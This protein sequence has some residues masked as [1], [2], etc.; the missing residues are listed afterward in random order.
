ME[1]IAR[2]DHRLVAYSRT[3]GEYLG[4]DCC[5]GTR[6]RTWAWSG[7]L[8]QARNM[9]RQYPAAEGYDLFWDGEEM[10]GRP[11]RVT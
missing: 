8:R 10:T 4:Y 11:V 3:R 7:T 5:A 2:R 1:L 9:V 6:D